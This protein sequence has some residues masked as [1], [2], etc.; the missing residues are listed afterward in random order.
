MTLS[1]YTRVTEGEDLFQGNKKARVW[2]KREEVSLGND[3]R[4]DGGRH[5]HRYSRDGFV[6]STLILDQKL[7]QLCEAP[8]PPIGASIRGCDL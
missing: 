7:Q 3:E 5:G 4:F 2:K 6:I 8:V 1:Q